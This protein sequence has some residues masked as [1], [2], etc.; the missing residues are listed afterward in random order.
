MARTVYLHALRA[1][2]QVLNDGS[3]FGV[4]HLLGSEVGDGL[5]DLLGA[6]PVHH[7]ASFLEQDP[8]DG[9]GKGLEALLFVVWMP[10]ERA[11]VDEEHGTADLGQERL[12]DLDLES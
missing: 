12:E 5:G 6:G 11:A 7:M 8:H 9:A 4:W 1:C 10:A 3:G 2:R